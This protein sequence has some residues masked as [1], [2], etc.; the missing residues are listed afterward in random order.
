MRD[1][2]QGGSKRREKKELTVNLDM[3]G[4]FLQDFSIGVGGVW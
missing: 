4:L 2:H 1:E 3:L